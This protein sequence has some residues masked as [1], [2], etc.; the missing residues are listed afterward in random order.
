ML[1][2]PQEFE[3]LSELIILTISR[4]DIS[5]KIKLLGEKLSSRLCSPEQEHTFGLME[6]TE[7]EKK[8]LNSLATQVL[9]EQVVSP[10]FKIISV[11]L[12]GVLLVMSFIRF[13][14]SFKFQLHLSISGL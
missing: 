11:L 6:A 3:F 10:I 12:F 13:H 4:A 8:L 7:V 1:S 9:S 2:N 14:C 5:S